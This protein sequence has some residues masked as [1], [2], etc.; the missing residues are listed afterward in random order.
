VRPPHFHTPHQND[1]ASEQ[2][3]SRSR[4]LVK[5]A[6]DQHERH[7]ATGSFVEA[8]NRGLT[9]PVPLAATVHVHAHPG[10]DALLG[11]PDVEFIA[12]SE[13]NRDRLPALLRGRLSSRG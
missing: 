4:L 13:A 6:T 9:L 3:K 10:T 11:R 2:G 7:D 12:V 1:Q 5:P 8:L